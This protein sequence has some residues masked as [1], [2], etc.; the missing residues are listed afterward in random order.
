[1]VVLAGGALTLNH[2]L[3]G[4][5]Y[6]DGLYAG[7]AVALGEGLGY[8]HPHLPGAPAAIHYPP[9]YPLLLAPLFATLSVETAAFAAKI[10]NL[11]LGA[12]GA[13]LVAWY[14]VRANLLGDRAPA[15]LAP[16]LVAASALS[17]PVLAI[18]SVLFA[19]P[20]FGVWLAAAVI[21]AGDSSAALVFH[22]FRRACRDWPRRSRCSPA[23]W[24]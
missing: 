13:G 16:A 9:L 21:L 4:V 11:L 19:E 12:I 3:V 5:F 20:L 15:W 23:P 17:M 22:H 2:D 10:L 14:A 6:D 8:V 7:L 1:M 18:Q 24:V